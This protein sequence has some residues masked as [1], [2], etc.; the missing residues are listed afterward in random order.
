MK[1]KNDQKIL[2]L[3]EKYGPLTSSEIVF[4][5]KKTYNMN[6]NA[7]RQ[8]IHR[9]LKR[10]TI[11]KYSDISLPHNQ[12][13]YHLEEHKEYQ[14]KKKILKSIETYDQISNRLISAL[15]DNDFLY[16][17][18]AVKILAAPLSENR[19]AYGKEDRR[20]CDI[21]L[22]SLKEAKI[23]KVI[24]ESDKNDCYIKLYRNSKKLNL[25]LRNRQ[26]QLQ[27]SKDLLKDSLTV[28]EKMSMIGWN[29]SYV[30]SLDQENN[31]Y[32]NY[33]F[34]AIG[35]SYKYDDY[36]YKHDK[37]KGMPVLIDIIVHR[38]VKLYDVTSFN[39]RINNVKNKFKTTDFRRITPIFFVISIDKK[40]LKFCK[41]KGF[42]IINLSDLFGK[43]ST[44]TLKKIIKVAQESHSS[45][46]KEY[47]ELI[48]NDGRFNN[49]K[50][51]LFNYIV[52]Q[53]LTNKLNITTSIGVKYEYQK[54]SCECDIVTSSTECILIFETKGYAKKTLVKLGIDQNTKDS[55]KRFFERTRNIVT[56]S[57][58]NIP[59]V[60]IFV[61]TS[62]FE[63]SAKEYMNAQKKQL[64]LLKKHYPMTYKL[65]DG[66]LYVD[67]EKL[68]KICSDNANKE[69]KEILK[70]YFK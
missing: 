52:A 22:K 21:I 36:Y 23:I 40:A 41:N 18:E 61:T 5:L 63:T 33:F 29:S 16:L 51:L 32:N 38:E 65:L 62:D 13:I 31:N 14:L 47:F 70:Q 67:R 68:L 17:E 10:Q 19:N 58:Y 59:V 6:S 15:Y 39:I 57:K 30:T 35:Y 25:L 24:N 9:A 60:T 66:Q 45:S 20:N 44:K 69:I 48:E 28:L 26:I 46:F 43:S 1:S 7:I 55:V 49:L 11:Q 53:L 54:N 56:K 3:L 50:G 64:F 37:K 2:K 12:F 27:F 8:I 4:N 42:L 34:N